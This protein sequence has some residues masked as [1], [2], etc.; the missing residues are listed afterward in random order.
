MG[1]GFYVLA[2]PMEGLINTHSMG[3]FLQLPHRA[4]KIHCK[5]NMVVYG[6]VSY[7]GDLKDMKKTSR[8]RWD[9]IWHGPWTTAIALEIFRS[10]S[11]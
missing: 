8:G 10:L 4:Q 7:C 11:F 5:A 3:A 1:D 6:S 9:A 2:L